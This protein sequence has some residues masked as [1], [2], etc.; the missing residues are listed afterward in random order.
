MRVYV[1][2]CVL[3]GEGRMRRLASMKSLT[4]C[5]VTFIVVI[6]FFSYNVVPVSAGEPSLVEVFNHLGFTNVAVTAV[7][8]FPAG[9]YTITLYA[10][11]AG[12]H[13]ENELSYYEVNT[14]T[15]NLLFAGPE[16]GFGYISPPIVKKFTAAKEFGLSMFTPEFHRYFTQNSL[17]PDGQIHSKVYRNLDDPK[18]FLIGFENIYGAGDRDYQDMVFSIRADPLPVGG[19][20][21]AL[22]KYVAKTPLTCY[23][24]L[25]SIF[26]I[27]ISLIRRKRE[28]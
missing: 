18:M 19:M 25:L 2:A 26:G 15:Y 12:Y 8:T 24:I 17:N 6:L 20:E 14:T 21:V 23:T 27:A 9:T 1:K 3:N 10:E 16:G 22:P 7:E 11:F 13:N 5:F 4:F 28:S